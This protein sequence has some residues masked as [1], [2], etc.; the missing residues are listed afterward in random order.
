MSE[1]AWSK[2]LVAPPEPT[3]LPLHPVAQTRLEKGEV[4]MSK[5]TIVHKA[6]EWNRSDMLKERVSLVVFRKDNRSSVIPVIDSNNKRPHP[7][8][9]AYDDYSVVEKPSFFRCAQVRAHSNGLLHFINGYLPKELRKECL[10]E[11][12]SM[13]IQPEDVNDYDPGKLLPT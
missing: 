11:L 3:P 4:V 13:V 12:R 1:N 8:D 2:P 9:V 6:H 7:H 10:K 5:L